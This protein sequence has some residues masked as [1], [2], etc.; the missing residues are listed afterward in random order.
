MYSSFPLE[1]AVSKTRHF[2]RAKRV[3]GMQRAKPV[4]DLSAS[5]IAIR[6]I[7][8]RWVETIKMPV[9]ATLITSNNLASTKR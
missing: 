5:M 9:S 6:S 7:G 3:I 1:L 4:T 8:K 2:H